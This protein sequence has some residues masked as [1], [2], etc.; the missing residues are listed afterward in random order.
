MA[1]PTVNDVQAVEP[2]L[3]NMLVG[4]MQDDMR[5]V[6]GRVFP[7]VQVDK[8]SGKYYIFDKKYFFSDD[9]EERA[10]GA[11][12][13]RI[14]VGVSTSTYSTL[15]WAADAAVADEERANSQ[16]PMDLETVK[17][18]RFAQAS[19]IRKERAWAADFM[20]N[21]VWGTTDNNSTTDWDDTSSGDP[22]GDVLTASRTVSNNTGVDPNSMVL[23]YIVHQAIVNH[24]DVLDRLKYTQAA[25]Q[26]AIEGALA[27][28]FGKTNYWV[29]KATYNTAN[30][31]ATFSASPIIDDDCL[32]CHVDP[33]AGIFGAT[34]GKTF[35]WPGGGGEGSMYSH[36]DDDRHATV[37]QHKEQWDQKAVATDL[38]YLFLDVV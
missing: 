8:D 27:A 10:P 24:P 17:V 37:I 14:D 7:T 23:G 9:L 32:V 19:M 34:A 22:V 30:E 6:A 26:A 25:T 21:S 20:A 2:V 3:T 29:A 31:S 1:L 33:A 4:Y 18:R 16:I 11:Q 28:I 12:F 38:G 15:Q 13:S 5:F 36:Y 35:A